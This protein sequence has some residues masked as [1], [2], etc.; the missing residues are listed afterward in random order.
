MRSSHFSSTLLR[1][2]PCSTSHALLT[3]VLAAAVACSTAGHRTEVPQA[4]GADISGAPSDTLRMLLT[5]ARDA[6]RRAPDAQRLYLLERV[7]QAQTRAHDFAGAEQTLAL[8]TAPASVGDTI[9]AAQRIETNLLCTLLERRRAADALQFVARVRPADDRSWLQARLARQMAAG[10]EAR[11]FVSAAGDDTTGQ[12]TRALDVARHITLPEARVDALL[13]VAEAAAKHPSFVARASREALDA[14]DGIR[15]RDRQQSRTAMLIP[16]LFQGGELELANRRFATLSDPRDRRYVAT[17]LVWNSPRYTTLPR[18][19]AQDALLDAIIRRVVDDAVHA[20]DPEVSR[21]VL[22]TLREALVHAGQR[23]RA[24]K[25][26]PERLV[27]SPS[28][29][30]PVVPSTLDRARTALNQHDFAAV[31]RLIS[32][33]NSGEREARAWTALAWETYMWNRDSAA[34]F[35][36]RARAA[37]VREPIDSAAFDAIASNIAQY[38]SWIGQQEAAISTINL[39]R[40]PD[41]TQYTVSEFGSSTFSTLTAPR[42]RTLASEVRRP[43]VRDQFFLRIITGYLLVRD[44]SPSDIAW[45][46]A[47]ADS[48]GTPAVRI[49]ARERVANDALT[50]GD[51]AS[52]REM[53]A[54]LLSQGV[55]SHL[56]T[57]FSAESGL[58]RAGGDRTLVAWALADA[59]AEIRTERLLRAAEVLERQLEVRR[60][61]P[62]IISNGPDM[63]RDQL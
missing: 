37:L 53:Y 50:R 14:L 8:V 30:P 42:L 46:R 47:L 58:A 35:L 9:T 1:A 29:S 61:E 12:L 34:T 16:P 44:A 57:R 19:S 41:A 55:P 25:L 4:K 33:M 24:D 60:R 36:E 63:C 21:S 54:A 6:A 48:I 22:A 26:V 11:L 56:A 43:A 18:L 39:V 10:H 27:P 13:A 17:S 51:S 59:P 62:R 32:A 38:Q 28:P 49:A 7:A 40:N 23:A 45:A 15:D 3:T 5:G 2:P 20:S 52:A 31:Q